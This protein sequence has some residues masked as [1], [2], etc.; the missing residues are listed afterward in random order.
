MQNLYL[1]PAVIVLL[2]LAVVVVHGAAHR[3]LHVDLE[4]WQNVFVWIVIVIGPL[5]VLPLLYIPKQ[6]RKAL[7]LL[8]ATMAGSLLFGVYF[9]FVHESNDH[10]RHRDQDVWG[11]MF[12]ASAVVLA[13]IE[14]IGCWVALRELGR[15]RKE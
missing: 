13:V 10:V 7:Y 4:L 11:I 1:H 14:V 6:R 5:L 9:H 8:A 2:H 15:Q 12:S 3:K